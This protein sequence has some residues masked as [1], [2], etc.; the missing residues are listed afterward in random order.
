[1]KHNLFSS[2]RWVGWF[3]GVLLAL[4]AMLSDLLS[5]FGDGRTSRPKNLSKCWFLAGVVLF[6]AT[7]P[8][9]H[10][11]EDIPMADPT[12][13]RFYDR[14]GDRVKQAQLHRVVGQCVDGYLQ[15][16]VQIGVEYSLERIDHRVLGVTAGWMVQ[17][18]FEGP[19]LRVSRRIESN[20]G[21]ADAISLWESDKFKE[22]LSK[23]SK[24]EQSHHIDQ[25]VDAI[26]TAVFKF[27][28]QSPASHRDFLV[29]VAQDWQ[30]DHNDLMQ[31][32]AASFAPPS[33][34]SARGMPDDPKT[35]GRGMR[36]G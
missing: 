24:K 8:P 16:N 2:S 14:G 1:M 10:A 17:G 20:Q 25:L 32:F 22:L 15:G 11:L 13:C 23:K 12:G 5:R 9:A 19:I 27:G 4:V 33:G 26:G 30:R 7:S 3:S 18:R 6:G 35:V 29:N 28:G 36:G 21:G 34:G 31:R